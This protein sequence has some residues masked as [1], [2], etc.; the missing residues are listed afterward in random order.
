[1]PED[2]LTFWFDELKPAQWWKKDAA[3]DAMIAE[4]FTDL[5]TQ[6]A[7]CELYSWRR[8]AHGRLAEILI[9]DQ[10]SR[11]MFRDTAQAFN[12]DPLA[13]AL[14]QEAVAVGADAGLTATQRSF[15]YM[16]YMH[17]ESLLI[18]ERAVELYTRNGVAENIKFEIKHKEII[19]RFGRYPHRNA[20]LGREST[21]E[22][23]AFL[24]Q[25]G[26]SF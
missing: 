10:F 26:S 20:I 11:N 7:S 18:H 6:A 4:R 5:H 23:L 22:E 3:F 15:L 9:L 2:I 24:K 12:A 14:A 21:A 17:S 19:E 25:P 8:T 1:M 16:P 13:L